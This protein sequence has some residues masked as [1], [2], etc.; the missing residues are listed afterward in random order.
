MWKCTLSH[1]HTHPHPYKQL[2]PQKSFQYTNVENSGH[3]KIYPLIQRIYPHH[4]SSKTRNVQTPNKNAC[5]CESSIR[6]RNEC[7]KCSLWIFIWVAIFYV[8]FS[9]SLFLFLI[10]SVAFFLLNNASTELNIFQTITHPHMHYTHKVIA[11]AHA[12]QLC[13]P[14]FPFFF[15]CRCHFLFTFS[16][17][18]WCQDIAGNKTT[19]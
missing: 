10:L 13:K 8:P 6:L 5:E 15:T 9:L 16:I 12:I 11:Q 17:D 18:S 7:I 19:T 2:N 3:T 4:R 14:H 1:A